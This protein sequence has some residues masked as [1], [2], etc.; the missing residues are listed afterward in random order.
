[1]RNGAAGAHQ[2]L[3]PSFAVAGTTLQLVQQHFCTRH[4]GP[5]Q[6]V[7]WPPPLDQFTEVR[8]T[9]PLSTTATIVASAAARA[10]SPCMIQ[11]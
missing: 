1:M 3:A 11:C 6:P 9:K 7:P 5:H 8:A 10:V 4:R 2:D